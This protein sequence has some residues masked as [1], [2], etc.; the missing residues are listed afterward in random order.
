MGSAPT[1]CVISNAPDVAG[2]SLVSVVD[3]EA[4]RISPRAYADWPVPP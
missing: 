3:E 4:Y 2:E 1:P